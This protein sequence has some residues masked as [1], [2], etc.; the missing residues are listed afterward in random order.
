MSKAK[1]IRQSTKVLLFNNANQIL[2]VHDPEK[3]WDFPGG[4]RD[5]HDRTGK[6]CIRRELR[7]E[8]GIDLRQFNELG[9]K[10]FDGRLRRLFQ[11]KVSGKPKVRLSVEHDDFMWVRIR[12]LPKDMKPKALILFKHVEKRKHIRQPSSRIRLAA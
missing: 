11:I 9:A 4:K 1:A 3:G 6:H 12:D 2:L 8:T 10:Y 7:E 5:E